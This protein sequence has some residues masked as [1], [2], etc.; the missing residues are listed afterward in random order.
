[1]YACAYTHITHTHMYLCVCVCMRGSSIPC[2]QFELYKQCSRMCA[3]ACTHITQTH[4]STH[5]HTTHVRT[6]TCTHAQTGEMAGTRWREALRRKVLRSAYLV[7]YILNINSNS[8]HTH[9]HTQTGEM[10]GTR[11]REA[12]RLKVL[13]SAYLGR[14]SEDILDRTFSAFCE[15]CCLRSSARSRWLYY[16]SK[17]LITAYTYSLPF[18]LASHIGW[19]TLPTSVVVAVALWTGDQISGY[20][21]P[22]ADGLPG[23]LMNTPGAC[24][25][26][27]DEV[28]SLVNKVRVCVCVCV[29]IMCVCVCVWECG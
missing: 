18:T 3:C 7:K 17:L 22:F 2:Y 10:V 24:R 5:T 9:T 8:S 21:E 13:L 12:L 1:M 15:A 6:H 23:T 19:W 28:L 29:C 14:E 20:T 27:V 11:W 26:V 4:I 25:I 16:V